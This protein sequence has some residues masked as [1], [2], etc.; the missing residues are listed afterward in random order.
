MAKNGVPNINFKRVMADIAQANWNAVMMIYGDGDP[1]LP[2][3]VYER[4]CLFHW[5]ASLNKVTQNSIK[6][7]L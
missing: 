2:M 5:F 6:S 3:V 1:N 7:F 4:T